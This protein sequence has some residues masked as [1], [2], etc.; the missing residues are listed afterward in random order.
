MEVLTNILEEIYNIEND[1]HIMIA[2]DFN[3]K[4]CVDENKEIEAIQDLFLDYNIPFKS[5]TSGQ[6]ITCYNHNEGTSSVD[7]LATGHNFPKLQ[8]NNL[9]TVSCRLRSCWST[10]HP[11]NA[12]V[13][14]EWNM[15]S[16][17][18]EKECI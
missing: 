11:Q 15:L 16:K 18:G 13:F 10:S 14:E 8:K 6:T 4:A 12:K 17:V 5:D 2:G 1:P 7:F 3:I 9:P